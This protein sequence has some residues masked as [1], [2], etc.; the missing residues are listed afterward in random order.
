MM[1]PNNE[2][3]YI[4]VT[5]DLKRRVYE[6]QNKLIDGFTRQYNVRKLV[7]FEAFED[8]RDAI[9]REKQIKAGS[10]IKKLGLISIKNPFFEDL[11]EKI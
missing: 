11:Y 2:V 8:I 1:S 4:G 9:Y 7:Y 5:N 3:I 6:H 10:R